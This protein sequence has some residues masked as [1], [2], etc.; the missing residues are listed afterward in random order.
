MIGIFDSG[1]GGMT[2]ARAI[3]QLCPG[4]P[5]LYF[6]D[7]IRTPYGSK[8]PEALVNCS[9]RNASFLKEKGATM[10]V[11]ACNSAASVATQTLVEEFDIPIIDVIEP[12]VEKAISVSKGNIGVIGTRATVQSSVYSKRIH[13]R[14]PDYKIHSTACPLFVPLV[15]EGWLNQRETKMIVKKYLHPLR[16]RQIDSLILGCTHYPLLKHLIQPRIGKKV[17]IV[18]SSI[19]TALYLQQ[20]LEKNES[21]KQSVYAPKKESLFFVS[22]LPNPTTKMAKSI[23]NRPIHLEQVNV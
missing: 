23:F 2:V 4:Y 21:L 5:L 22:D 17:H 9:R 8:S 19:E 20:Y 15:E 13:A 16:A 6:G 7:L 12:A 3:E 11:I 18:D 1:L 10:I 14:K